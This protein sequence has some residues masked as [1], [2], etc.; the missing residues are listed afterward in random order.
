MVWDL[1]VHD[2]SILHFFLNKMPHRYESRKFKTVSKNQEDTAYL[3]LS[4]KNLTT[5]NVLF[6]HDNINAVLPS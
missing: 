4:Y 1:T 3:N 5:S 2:V 6:S